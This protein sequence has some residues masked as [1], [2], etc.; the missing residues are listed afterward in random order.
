MSD[1]HMANDGYVV[2][3]SSSITYW[4]WSQVNQLTQLRNAY[5]FAGG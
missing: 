3:D 4:P 1:T 5:L 2:T